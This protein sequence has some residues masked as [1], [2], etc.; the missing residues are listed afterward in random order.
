MNIERYDDEI[1]DE[2]RWEEHI[3]DIERKSLELTNFFNQT[4]GNTSPSWVRLLDEYQNQNDVIDAYIEEAIINEEAYFPDDDDWDDEDED[5]PD[6]ELFMESS[7]EE[8]YNSTL[9]EKIDSL[10]EEVIHYTG[11]FRIED[12]EFVEDIY[13]YNLAREFGLKILALAE[14]YKELSA[15]H[16]FDVLVNTSLQMSAKLAIGFNLGF[17][18][19]VI[20]GNIIYSKKA[21]D[22]A[23]SALAL[24]CSLKSRNLL[25]QADYFELHQLLTNVR[26]EIGMYIQDLRESINLSNY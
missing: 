23:N 10:F 13:A 18:H 9:P 7:E 21:L 6:N 26:N 14:S 22:N 15:E 2:Y 17:D 4:W 8:E 20:G 11:E 12:M 16:F 24:L 19:E 1:W 5:E 25:L 3:N